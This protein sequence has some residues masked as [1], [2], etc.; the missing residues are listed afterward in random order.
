MIFWKLYWCFFK[1]GLLSFGG[2]YATLG[3]IKE[4]IVEKQGWLTMTNFT[5]IT[6]IS[7]MTP[8]P[9]AINSS[10]FVG[11]K[12]AGVWGGIIATIGCV[13][14]SCIIVML[15]ATIYFKYKNL[16]VVSGALYGL[17]PAV[18]A[19]IGKAAFSIIL[20]AFFGKEIK[21]LKE[22]DLN[23]LSIL[24]FTSSLILVQKFKINP[25]TVMLISGVIGGI[26]YNFDFIKNMI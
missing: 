16:K 14:P 26:V 2:G 5:D 12:I 22:I 17:R 1:I 10:T 13:T 25:I 4:E 3:V 9:V 18:I 21:N 23:Y 19:L 6:A 20:F 8:G 24:I 15:L 7:Q 11:V